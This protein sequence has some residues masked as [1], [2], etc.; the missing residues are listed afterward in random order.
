M[1]EALFRSSA[2]STTWLLG[3]QRT[4]TDAVSV[5]TWVGSQVAC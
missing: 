3:S 5:L 2:V 1:P 4:Y